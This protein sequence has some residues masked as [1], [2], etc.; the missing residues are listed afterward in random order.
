MPFTPT[1]M[2]TDNIMADTEDIT[3]RIITRQTQPMIKLIVWDTLLATTSAITEEITAMMR[4]LT[5]VMTR[6]DVMV[7]VTVKA[8]AV[9]VTPSKRF[10]NC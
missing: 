5:P 1:R 8:I 2:I 9:V 7:A 3:A 6:E 4:E 10:T